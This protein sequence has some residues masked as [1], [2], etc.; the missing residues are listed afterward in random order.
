MNWTTLAYSLAAVIGL[1]LVARWLR[2]G[3]SRLTSAAH[4]R[5][6]AEQMLVGF[7]AHDALLGTDGAAALVAGNGT[8]ALLKRHGAKV[9]ARRL[10]P[11]LR[12]S[13]DVEGVRIESGERLFGAVLLFGVTD[14]QVR[15]LE[16]SVETG[17]V[18]RGLTI[19]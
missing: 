2:L 4:A 9:A 18:V 13:Q 10:V 1:A 7:L 3:E 11:P 6:T 19:H 15:A 14:A 12:L 17:P 16:A 5:E 8:V